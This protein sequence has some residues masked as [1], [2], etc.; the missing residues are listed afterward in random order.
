MAVPTALATAGS[1]FASWVGPARRPSAVKPKAP[2]PVSLCLLQ[3]LARLECLAILSGDCK[4]PVTQYGSLNTQ[5]TAAPLAAFEPERRN[6]IC[7]GN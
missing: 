1:L 4:D 6:L 7:P 3:V 5:Q 2:A